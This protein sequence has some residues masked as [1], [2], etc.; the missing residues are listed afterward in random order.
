MSELQEQIQNRRRKREELARQGVE[1]YPHAFPHDLEP[2]E[3]HARWGERT[4]EELEAEKRH[5]RVP[6][7]MRGIREQGK[8]V[9]L[10]LARRPRQAAAL[11]A[12]A[13]AA[14]GGAARCSTT[15]TSAT[16]WAPSGTLDPHPRRR[17]LARR[18]RPGAARQGAA[19]A[20]REVARPG[21][22][23]GAL[24]P[25]LLD[26]IVNPESRR[27]FEM[28]AAH[29]RAA[30]ARFLDDR[31]FLE[32]ETP[33]MQLDRR[34]R[35]G[36]AVRH[37]PQRARPRPLPAHRARAVPQAAA[38]RRHARGS[39]RS[40]ATS[41]TRGSRPSTTP[42]SP[43]SSSTGRT[44]TTEHADGRSPRSCSSDLAQKLLH[45]DEPALAGRDGST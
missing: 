6:G 43:C 2:S 11:R 42:S 9:F 7:R 41:A 21:R 15:S 25:A 14:R 38:R 44:S 35:R 20:A 16:A 23:R 29:R 18:R 45:G 32:V 33:M 37:P 19:A 13:A 4:A 24:P 10:D 27:V 1:L 3:V 39:T 12:P 22:R 34:R 28:R 8:L 17:A 31:G 40:T 36:A 30:C 26:L 5:L